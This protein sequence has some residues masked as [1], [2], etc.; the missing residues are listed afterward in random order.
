MLDPADGK[1]L[2]EREVEGGSGLTFTDDALVVAQPAAHEPG[3]W[4]VRA[5]DAVSG[6]ARWSWTTPPGDAAGTA[7]LETSE[8]RVVLAVGSHAWVLTAS[9]EPVLD[10][11]LGTDSWLQPARAGVFVESTWTTSAYSGTLLLAD[12]SRVPVDE[13]AAWLAV[14]DGTAPDLLLT[15]GQAPGGAD[16]L[17]GR[18]ARTGEPR[19]HVPG[20]IVTALL[21]DGTVYV[22]TT[23]ALVAV[24][25]G[26][27]H[28]R[29]STEIDHLP[30]QLS[31]D[32]RYLLLPGPGVTLEAY[33]LTD[34]ELAWTADLAHEVAGDRDDRVRAGLPVG[35]ARPP[36]V[37]VDGH[38]RRRGPGL[39]R[40]PHRRARAPRTRRARRR[41]GRDRRGRPRRAPVRLAASARRP[42]GRRGRGPPARPWP[43]CSPC[44]TRGSARDWS[45][46]P[47][48]PGCSARCTTRPVRCGRGRRARA[49][50]S[51]RTPPGAGPS[52]RATTSAG[53]DLRGT[54]PDTG[55]VLWSVPFSL[56]AAVRRARPPGVPVGLGALHHD[57]LQP[58]APGRSAPRR[59]PRRAPAAPSPRLLV[60]DP[61][62]GRTLATA[63]LAAR[64][65]VVGDGV[66]PGRRDPAAG[67]RRR[68]AL[69]RHRDRPGHRGP[70]SGADGPRSC[71]RSTRCASATA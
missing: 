17:T 28:V 48:S 46:S 4:E 6:A 24:D 51:P 13:T 1:L 35:L 54:D 12:G 56:A 49:P 37:R 70:C 59:S 11:A 21:L 68:R 36:A 60:L 23:N 61:P 43:A 9:G 66:A 2:A 33:T 30:Q 27:G 31:T 29:W 71:P 57:D 7:S 20:T 55:D 41:A 22:A 42:G 40:G 18:S 67:R 64:F 34:G 19:W 50:S 15:V 39:S 47:T 32:G 52:A 69:D 10:T 62:T 5:T 25:A 16:G 3:R 65:A 38:R 26:T 8:D 14:D 45:T 44:S 53:V 58:T 63:S